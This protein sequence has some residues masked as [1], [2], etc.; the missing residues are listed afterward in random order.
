MPSVTIG[1]PAGVSTATAPTA[2]TVAGR[3]GL[4]VWVRRGWNAE[5]QQLDNWTLIPYLTPI[6]ATISAFPGRST[7]ELRYDFGVLRREDNRLL[8]NFQYQVF[9]PLDVTDL[10]VAIV[11]SPDIS[12]RR[13]GARYHTVWLGVIQTDQLEL[14]GV[15]QSGTPDASGY[16]TIQCAGLESILERR[17]VWR[18]W[19]ENAGD[20]Y[21]LDWTPMFNERM[22]HGFHTRPNRSAGRI[23]APRWV[24][25]A[26][27]G[28]SYGFASFLYGDAAPAYWST[29]DILEYLLYWSNDPSGVYENAVRDAAFRIDGWDPNLADPPDAL[30]NYLQRLYP[31]LDPD[32]RNVWSMI[33][34]LIDRRRGISGR[35]TWSEHSGDYGDPLAVA[36]Q[37]VGLP[38]TRA[39]IGIELFSLLDEDVAVGNETLPGNPVIEQLNI[40]E[41][42][43][44]RAR[45]VIDTVDRYERLIVRGER[46]L[47][48]FSASPGLDVVYNLASMS[49][50]WTASEEAAYKAAANDEERKRMIYDRVWCAFRLGFEADREFTWKLPLDN[51]SLNPSFDLS[52]NIQL[53][54]HNEATWLAGKKIDDVL[55][56]VAQ[57]DEGF[58]STL[59]AYEKP[60]VFLRLEGALK[61]AGGADPYFTRGD[62]AKSGCHLRMSDRDMEVRVECTPAHLIGKGTFDSPTKPY[63]SADPLYDHRYIVATIAVRTDSRPMVVET[64]PSLGERPTYRHRELVIDVPDCE[65]WIMAPTTVIG[66]NANGS[67][68]FWTGPR[69]VRDD[70]D[71][72]RQT[73]ALAKAWFH[74]LRAALV[75]TAPGLEPTPDI[76]TLVLNIRAGQIF[77]EVRSVVT[78][79]R[80]DFAKRT[81][82]IV[83]G[84]LELDLR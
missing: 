78:E 39:P 46:L 21:P 26:S 48:C 43:G 35:F 82:E 75:Y 62:M 49:K 80:L 53:D 4:S 2:G 10:Y 57:A 23:T 54:Q 83:T 51:T 76:G 61:P 42:H 67:L 20:A 81:T 24:D 65:V 45:V 29:M 9:N 77:R 72:L 31:T 38:D 69:V 6:K 30:H 63:P 47:S 7:A 59:P 27:E 84:M 28:V 19:V 15:P 11:V 41:G 71:R 40:D 68:Q 60:L 16:Q 55:P 74:K 36:G 33:N 37:R 66:T 73:A 32:R 44:K 18:G 8:T 34:E 58:E 50:A 5:A 56:F 79:R 13:T 52:G 17:Q 1:G 12:S 22:R 25:L 64:L 70:T 14:L 3:Q